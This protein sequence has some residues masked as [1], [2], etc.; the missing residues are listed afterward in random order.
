[1]RIPVKIVSFVLFFESLKHLKIALAH[2]P[3]HFYPTLQTA[4]YS[5]SPTLETLSLCVQD[6]DFHVAYFPDISWP[7]LKQIQIIKCNNF[8]F[9]NLWSNCPKIEL[10]SLRD[11]KN[12]TE[13]IR[14]IAT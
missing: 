14:W 4:L 5:H 3:A 7:K 9:S 1:M 10:I 12:D 11:H 13:D 6:C 2:A 8:N